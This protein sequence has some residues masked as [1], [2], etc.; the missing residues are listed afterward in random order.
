MT[1]QQLKHRILLFSPHCGNVHC[2]SSVQQ[3]KEKEKYNIYK[4]FTASVYKFI[5]CIHIYIYT[6]HTWNKWKSMN[7]NNNNIWNVFLS[8]STGDVH[9]S[10]LSQKWRQNF[11]CDLQNIWRSLEVLNVSHY[12]RVMRS[13]SAQRRS[14][15]THI[16]TYLT[17]RACYSALSGSLMYKPS[18]NRKYQQEVPTG[19]PQEALEAGRPRASVSGVSVVHLVSIESG[20]RP[21]ASFFLTQEDLTVLHSC[22]VVWLFEELEWRWRRPRG[23]PLQVSSVSVWR[24]SCLIP[25]SGSALWKTTSPSKFPS[26]RKRCTSSTEASS[27]MKVS[28]VAVRAC[29]ASAGRSGAHAAIGQQVALL[30][31]SPSTHMSRHISFNSCCFH[32]NSEVAYQTLE[33]KYPKCVKNFNE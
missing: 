14:I 26:R 4:I 28:S 6:V 2:Y 10:R 16:I 7:N 29:C 3:T 18:T 5:L 8:L 30:Q 33:I 31:F 15:E 23:S 24:T 1:Q 12:R 25:R 20:R 22:S 9:S 32:I 17:R 21:T 13:L 19:S 11:F 27:C